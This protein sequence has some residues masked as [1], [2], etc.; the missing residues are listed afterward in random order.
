MAAEKS[1][2]VLHTNVNKIELW[3]WVLKYEELEIQH[4]HILPTD[5][6]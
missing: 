1:T 3:V 2:C 4:S 5:R 6:R